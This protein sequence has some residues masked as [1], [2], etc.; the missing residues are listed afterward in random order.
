MGTP[1]FA[2]NSLERLIKEGYN[3]EAVVTQPDRPRGRGKRIQ[4]PPVKVRAAAEGIPVMQPGRVK[5]SEFINHLKSI[6]PDIII[7]VAFGQILPPEIISLPPLGCINVHASLLPKYRGAA[8]I[9]WCIINGETKTGV[10]TMFM[11]E[12]MDTGD[13]LLN[14]VTGIDGD[15]TAGQLHDRLA[16]MGAKLLVET[17]EGLKNGS[18]VRK[19]QD[20]AKATYAPQLC[21]DDGRIYWS[22]DARSIFNLIRGTDPWPGCFSYLNGK[23]IKLCKAKVLE[24]ES[25][26]TDG[27]IIAVEDEGITVQ[28]GRGS[29]LITEIQVPS[30]RRMTAAEYLRGNTIKVKDILG[31]KRHE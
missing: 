9:N 7:V 26:G 15:E 3:I 25:R 10:T 22:R 30:S 1:E 24:E 5:D 12:G 13:M 27:E 20:S 14:K 16:V 18:L 6:K 4:P 2:V 11:D 19:V 29:L 31:E 8:P 23:R 21:R 17:I 28:T